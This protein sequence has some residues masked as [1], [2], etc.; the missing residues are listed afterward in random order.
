MA[1]D[2]QHLKKAAALAYDYDRDERWSEYWSNVL[3]PDNRSKSDVERYFKF[4]FYQRNIV[5][6]LFLSL[7]VVLPL[8][9]YAF[10]VFVLCESDLVL[11]I[12]N[13]RFCWVYIFFPTL[14]NF[15][16]NTALYELPPPAF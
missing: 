14:L 7:L 4:K 8:S 13:L 9:W 15:S 10:F 12:R 1:E 2:N 5:G 3:I 16:W 11:V 6:S